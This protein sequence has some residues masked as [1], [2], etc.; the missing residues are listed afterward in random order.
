MNAREIALKILYDVDV[1]GA[2]SNISM[3]KHFNK[4]SLRSEEKALAT[5]LAN[6]VL[7]HMGTLDRIIEMHSS[8]KL[9]KISAYIMNI[10]RLGTYQIVFLDRIPKSAACDE[11]VKLAK[12]YGNPGSAGF[13]NAVLRNIDKEKE[14][15]F[16]NGLSDTSED[17]SIRYSY[18]Q[19]IAQKWI[20]DY[21]AEFAANLMSAGNMNPPTAIRTNTLKISRRELQKALYEQGIETEDSK[22]AKDGLL[23]KKAGGLF[24]SKAYNEGLFIVQDQSAMLVSEILDPQPGEYVIDLCSAPG[25]KTTHIAQLMDNKGSITARDIHEH[26]IEIVEKLAAKLGID[27]ISVQKSDALQIDKNLVSK[28]DRVLADVPCS[29]LGILARRPEIKNRRKPEDIKELSEI[30]YEIISNAAKYVKPGGIL[31][32]STCTIG[33]AENEEIVDRFL[34][35]NSDFEPDNIS[36][37]LPDELKKQSLKGSIQIF[38][39]I[40]AM[41]GFFI[42]RLKRKKYE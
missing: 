10:L 14:N 40:N 6:G 42:S 35:E 33:S 9:K 4:Y 20:D 8:I 22:T 1:N 2:Y 29:G 28:A 38:P 26:K 32:Y 37:Y 21:G 25:G 12:K 7:K 30:Q 16:I 13:V 17:L 5:E 11:A 24:E 41:D 3:S 15:E 23:V 18:P 31:V 27:I 36:E 34:K 19:W 39:N